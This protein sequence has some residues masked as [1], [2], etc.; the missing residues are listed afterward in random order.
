MPRR[1]VHA[2]SGIGPFSAPPPAARVRGGRRGVR[3]AAGQGPARCFD[4][5]PASRERRNTHLLE[6]LSAARVR[7]GRRRVREAAGQGLVALVDPSPTSREWR[8]TYL[9][10]PLWAARVRGKVR[11]AFAD[12]IP[13]ALRMITHASRPFDRIRE[14]ARG[15]TLAEKRLTATPPRH[16][17][18]IKSITI[19]ALTM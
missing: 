4:P 14:A 6:P 7:G 9:F 11:H 13:L 15:T 19:R 5:S 16:N 3:E 17:C 12:G 1:V 2:S 10:G 18:N 8:N